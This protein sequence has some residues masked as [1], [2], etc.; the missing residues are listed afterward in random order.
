MQRGDFVFVLLDELLEGLDDLLRAL[1]RGFGEAGFEDSV[2]RD[3]VDNLI[4]FRF[5]REDDLAQLGV[6][7]RLD[8]FD[9]GG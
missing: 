5:Q 3:G 2:L 8:G 1:A 9:T 7:E 6:I 4:V